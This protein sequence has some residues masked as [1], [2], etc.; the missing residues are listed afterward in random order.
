MR[1]LVR[2]G[3]QIIAFLG[4]DPLPEPKAFPEEAWKIR[5]RTGSTQ[6]QLARRLEFNGST[7]RDWERASIG[8]RHSLAAGSDSLPGRVDARFRRAD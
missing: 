8:R 7:I 5:W 1:P 2:Y 3:A 4:Y 6:R